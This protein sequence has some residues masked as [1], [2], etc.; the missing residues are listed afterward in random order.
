[1]KVYDNV[2]KET[3]DILKNQNYQELKVDGSLSWN[4]LS[5]N[6][7][8]MDR[9][10]AFELGDR[11]RP[12]TVYNAQTSQTDVISSDRILLFGK[13]LNEISENT[14]FSRITFFNVDEIENA[15]K[16][17]IGIKKLE[18]ER[19]KMIPEGYMILSSSLA[20]RENIRVSKK[21]VSQGINFDIIGNLYLNHY[22]KLEGVNH[23]WIIF[24]VGDYPF[25]DQLINLSK[26]VDKITEA[27]DHILKNVILDCAVCP[28][29][30]ICEDVE[31][32]RELHF[33]QIDEKRKR[34]FEKK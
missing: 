30:P 21:A 24:L 10:I 17:Y 6:E 28:L 33:S 5:N 25:M 12:C 16:A 19:F 11:M 4:C 23:A 2:I 8:L 29:K 3:W 9:D 1:M 32:L 31:A 26:E 22:K 13:N 34:L 27:Y 7:F 20:N 15:N 18:Y 14:N